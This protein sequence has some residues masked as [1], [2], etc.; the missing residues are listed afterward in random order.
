VRN[1]GEK[2]EPQERFEP[3]LRRDDVPTDV[4]ECLRQRAH[5]RSPEAEALLLLERG[6]RAEPAGPSQTPR[7]AE[8]RRHRFPPLAWKP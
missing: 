6:L 8:L 4:Y 5:A 7:L 3:F 1:A 2:R